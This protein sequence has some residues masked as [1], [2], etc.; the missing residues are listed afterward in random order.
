MMRGDECL[1]IA[2]RQIFVD[3][4][5]YIPLTEGDNQ[6]LLSVFRGSR[7]C[8]PPTTDD[9]VSDD[10]EESAPDTFLLVFEWC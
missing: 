9:A 2:S 4:T 10:G 5:T 3:S 8:N 1:L 7:V 6:K